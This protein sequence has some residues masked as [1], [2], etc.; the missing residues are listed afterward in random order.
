MRKSVRKSVLV[1]CILVVLAALV[2]IHLRHNSTNTPEISAQ[3]ETS[4]VNLPPPQAVAKADGYQ[5]IVGGKPRF[6]KERVF[7]PPTN[8]VAITNEAQLRLL[9]E[10]SRPRQNQSTNAQ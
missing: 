10:Q 9:I 7:L 1:V 5:L 3:V 6:N 2:A 4:G 8:S